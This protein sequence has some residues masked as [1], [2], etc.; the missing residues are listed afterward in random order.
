[1]KQALLLGFLSFFL[2]NCG[3]DITDEGTQGEFPEPR[4]D[5]IEST[6]NTAVESSPTTIESTQETLEALRANNGYVPKPKNAFQDKI[7]QLD[8]EE[9]EIFL[10]KAVI[11]NEN[12]LVKATLGAL[13]EQ[14]KKL[15]VNKQDPLGYTLLHSAALN[16]NVEIAKLLLDSGAD[17]NLKDRRAQK[18]PLDLAQ[19]QKENYGVKNQE[20]ISLLEDRTRGAIGNLI[21][22]FLNDRD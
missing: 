14:E 21:Y 10:K 8:A 12:D 7:V 1:M 20:L 17:A 9:R 3:G 11:N 6:P 16:N 5:T 13:S 18:T 15:E 22:Y 4:Q 19:D 2:L